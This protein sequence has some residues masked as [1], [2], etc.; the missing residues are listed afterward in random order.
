MISYQYA[1]EIIKKVNIYNRENAL[2]EYRKQH[3]PNLPSRLHSIWLTDDIGKDFWKKSLGENTIS[4]KV[5]V[6]GNLFKSSH[7]FI[8]D[9]RLNVKEMYDSSE[10]YWNPIFKNELEERHTE[11]LFQGKLKILEKIKQN[12]I[13]F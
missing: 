11:Y 5:L 2:E 9:D 6:S 10:Y 7:E 1:S 4:Y 3:F 13:Y 12:L 8:P